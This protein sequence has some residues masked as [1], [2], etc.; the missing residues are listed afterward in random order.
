MAEILEKDLSFKITG[1]CY[2][3][4]NKLGRFC[5][6]RQY[7]DELEQQFLAA[8]IKNKREFEIQKLVPNAPKGNRVDFMVED[9]VP[10][11]IKAKKFIT[12]EDYDQMQRYLEAA[13]KKLGLIVNFRM[14]FIKPKR[15]INSRYDSRHS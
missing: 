9:R 13:D 14:T 6:E 11:D 8:S 7:C 12:K 15:I 5:S 1:C 10:L 4:H 2:K 3:T